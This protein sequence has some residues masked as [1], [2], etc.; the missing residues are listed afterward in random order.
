M[1]KLLLID[2]S[3][4]GAAYSAEAAKSLNLE[5]VFLANLN[6]YQGDTRRQIL[7]YEH[8]DADTSSIN[9]MLNA[10]RVNNITEIAGV[11][12]TLDSKL[13]IAVD[14]AHHLQ[15]RSIDKVVKNLVSKKNVATLIPEFSPKTWTFDS[16]DGL[17]LE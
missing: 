6:N 15:V 10:I 7:K 11:I 4:V 3:D 2:T 1:N 14:L 13:N 12:T 17:G 9:S 8:Y 16:S 5:P